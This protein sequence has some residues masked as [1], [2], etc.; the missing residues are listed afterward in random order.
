MPIPPPGSIEALIR[1]L[2]T[3]G[4]FGPNVVDATRLPSA[5]ARYGPWPA[6]LHP[7]VRAAAA[8]LGLAELYIHQSDAV[9]R[10]LAGEHV[11]VVSGT[12]S[13]KSLCYLLPIV[14]ALV[15]SPD[16]RALLLF[17]TKA[18]AHDQL[19]ALG[20]WA[21]ALPAGLVR[22]A[23][24]DGDTPAGRRA[25][26]RRTANVVVT[27]P[28][29]LHAGILPHH[30]DW[31]TFLHGLSHVVVDEMHV[32]RGVFG[33]HVANVL[34]R[35]WR[36]AR[37]H[38]SAP[39]CLLT[40]ATIANPGELAARLVGAT[41][42][43]VADDGAPRG[44]RTFVF[45]NP[46]VVDE[47][48][49]LRRSPLLEAEAV[50]RHFVL[51]GVQTIVFARSRQ[52][53]ELIVRYLG[54]AVG[55]AQVDAAVVGPAESAVAATETVRGYRGGYLP[56][57]RR[58]TEA[59][60]RTGA[61]RCV[62]ATNALELGIDIGA[63]DACVMAGYPGTVAS[64]LQ[65][66]GRAG[67]RSGGAAAVL[68]AGPTALDQY[69]VRHP[70]HILGRSPEHARIDPD[71]L[72]ILL[73]H[74][75]CAAFE[76]PFGADEAGRPFGAT[77]LVPAP[78]ATAPGIAM[79]AGEPAGA[80]TPTVGQLLAV[81]AAQR[82]VRQAGDTWYWLADAY[83]AEAVSLRTSGPSDVTIV[84]ELTEPDGAGSYAVLGTVGRDL[85]PV[86]VHEGA[87]YLHDGATYRVQ[88]LDWEGGRAMVVPI[89]DS[90]YTRAS[91][92][93]DVRPTRVF[94]ERPATHAQVAHGELE[95]R[96]RATGFRTVRFRTHETLA[97]SPIDLPEQVLVT[98][99]YWFTLDEAAVDRLRAIGHWDFDPSGDRGPDWER[100]RALALA[101]DGHRCQ[102]C[103]VPETPARPQHV[104]HIRPFRTFGWAKG[105]NE[106]WRA[107]NQLDNL[108]TLCSSCHQAAERALGLHGGLSGLGYALGNIAPLY[109]MCDPRDL[110]VATSVHAP[111]SRRPTVVLHER[112]A[113]GVGFGE[114]LY[115][116]HAE[117]LT[118]CSRLI[119]DCPCPRGCPGCVGPTDE[120][121]PDAKAHALAVLAVLGAPAR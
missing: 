62:V 19:A 112:A 21:A 5:A 16:A 101:R 117:L 31:G 116:L 30:T 95:I 82:D 86:T 67:R 118:T 73:D 29:M 93:V 22:P 83:P 80:A 3:D 108:M 33:S 36:I 51:G 49:N 12:A 57:E 11:A 94:A 41:V 114:T 89:D 10:A 97:W 46:P 26:I 70:E 53:A 1:T 75:R 76:L 63:L 121:G 110:G 8:D 32:Y 100:Q 120:R 28:D 115:Q 24:Y 56:G 102:L 111:W 113:A 92:S 85:A 72:L 66:A 79:M 47:T 6:A 48:L 69:V 25:A 64:T 27:N 61:L 37:F 20:G 90:V 9:A 104:H 17:P 4:R 68:V 43:V 2:R 107:A 87:V 34:R 77:P 65:Q 23:A 103:G 105:D 38:G 88:S 74:V 7:R 91:A 60:L 58:A 55:R 40:S 96:S 13:G 119:A 71:N 35:L 39:H 78:P 106:A 44:A 59:A 84:Q 109:L 52:S 18:L 45:Y 99:G 15:R 14:D 54:E 98:G 81:L 50:A 42:A